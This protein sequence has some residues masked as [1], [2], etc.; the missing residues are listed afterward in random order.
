MGLCVRNENGGGRSLR[1]LDGVCYVLEN[2]QAEVLGASLLGICASDDFCACRVVSMPAGAIY[3]ATCSLGRIPYSMA[4]CAWKLGEA[5]SAA[6]QLH[7]MQL[8]LTFPAFL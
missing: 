5:V 4:C 2:G 8:L 7:R 1:F 6:D 3:V